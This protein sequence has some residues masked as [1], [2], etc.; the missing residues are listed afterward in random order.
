MKDSELL[1]KYGT[2]F[3]NTTHQISP[4]LHLCFNNNKPNVK[5]EHFCLHT[6]KFFSS[7]VFVSS[8]QED[9]SDFCSLNSV[10]MSGY[11]HIHRN[12]HIAPLI[13]KHSETYLCTAV[14][15]SVSVLAAAREILHQNRGEDADHAV[16][17]SLP[18][19]IILV[20]LS[21]QNADDGTFRKRQL[22]IRLSRVVVQRLRKWHCNRRRAGWELQQDMLELICRSNPHRWSL[23]WPSRLRVRSQVQW[24]CWRNAIWRPAQLKPAACSG[25]CWRKEAAGISL[26]RS[27]PVHCGFWPGNDDDDTW[28]EF[29]SL[30]T[31]IKSRWNAGI[32]I[33]REHHLDP[34]LHVSVINDLQDFLLLNGQFIR[35]RRLE[36]RKQTREV[37]T[38][39]H[40]S[41]WRE[42]L[43]WI[44]F[45][46][47][48]FNVFV[49]QDFNLLHDHFGGFNLWKCW[50][51]FK[52]SVSSYQYWLTC[53]SWNGK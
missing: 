26:G 44:R 7:D 29:L 32:S 17:L 24:S 8:E 11:S 30:T 13:V 33:K 51:C 39:F 23:R 37:F 4:N 36:T 15:L 34:V 45:T 43:I 50:I 47:S 48:W 3:L 52:L 1:D 9:T 31:L 38:S 42:K 19:T 16:E 25:G 20:G 46:L 14:S 18:E 2:R 41:W 35:L 53:L 10:V 5:E 12:S 49:L 6:I 28:W 21:A 27:R 40:C 22:V